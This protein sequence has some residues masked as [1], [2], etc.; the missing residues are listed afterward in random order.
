MSILTTIQQHAETRPDHTALRGSHVSIPYK[1]L[2]AEINAAAAFI[3]QSG[4]PQ[5]RPQAVAIAMENDPAWA[6]LDL[7]CLQLQLPVVP[8]PGFFSPQQ[9]MH[10]IQDAGID[11]LFCQQPMVMEQLLLAQGYRIVRKHHQL[12]GGQLVSR[13]Q[14]ENP[15][16]RAL[17]AG[18]AKVTYTSGTTG[19]PKGV[20]LSAQAM[21]Q[22]SRSLADAT[23]ASAEDSHLSILPLSTLLENIAGLYLP[24]LVGATTTL[25]SSSRVGLSGASGLNVPQLLRT[26]QETNPTTLLLIPELLRALVMAA[27]SGW[28]PP[29]S[30]RLIA[31][32]GA[33]VAPRLLQRAVELGLPVCEGYGLSECASVVA[34]NAPGQQR[35]GSVGKLLPHVQLAFASDGELLVAGSTLLGYAAQP[36]IHVTYWPTGDIGYLDKDGYL[37]ITG[38]KKNIYITSYGRNVSPE[39]VESELALS[40]VIAQVAVFGEARPW[41]VAVIV[42][43]VSGDITAQ[44]E[45]AVQQANQTLPDYARVQQW[46]LA[47]HPFSP[48]NQQLTPNGRLRRDAIWQQYA[49]RINPLYEREHH[50]VL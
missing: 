48:Q 11:T 10:A 27:E 2:P 21:E 49:A 38:R 15:E 14:F 41:S 7:A 22:V 24:L 12:V 45:A 31:V 30:L 39:W 19:Q 23:A 4:L 3:Q 35:P 50:E 32:G 36:A 9:I 1:S 42:P 25:Y 29:A 43:H 5:E 37:H 17:P 40:P 33:R 18:T 20:C 47:E 28:V 8:L 6:V 13:L 34:F 44:I 46:I 26:I 16:P